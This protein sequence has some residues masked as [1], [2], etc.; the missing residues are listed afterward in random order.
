[1]DM[2]WINLLF[3]LKNG[4]LDFQNEKKDEF[5]LCR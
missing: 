1:M 4:H 5:E 2:K 3:F